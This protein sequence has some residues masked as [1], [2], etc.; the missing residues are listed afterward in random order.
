MRSLIKHF[1]IAVHTQTEIKPFLYK[2]LS[3]FIIPII[4]EATDTTSI[5]AFHRQK[6]LANKT[7]R[8]NPSIPQQKFYKTSSVDSGKGSSMFD[9][10]Y[11]FV[12]NEFFFIFTLSRNPSAM[13][14]SMDDVPSVSLSSY[15]QPN[16]VQNPPPPHPRQPLQMIS[17]FRKQETLE[18]CGKTY[19][20]LNLL[21]KG[22]S[23]TVRNMF[24]GT[25]FNSY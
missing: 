10:H 5:M 22:G 8:L 16:L 25:F 6:L 18:I 11:F 1:P 15:S 3:K 7:N 12:F 14:I 17:T 19:R 2:F 4:L 20:I 9:F 21:G 13:S 23:S 24:W